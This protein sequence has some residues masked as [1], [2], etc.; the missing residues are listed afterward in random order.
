MT[1]INANTP[2]LK[3][4]KDMIDAYITLDISKVEPFVSKSFKYQTFPKVAD[5][6]EEPK[7]AHIQRF[8][9]MLAVMNKFEVRISNTGEAHQIRRLI[10]PTPRSFPTK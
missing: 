1:D 4:V 2:Q 3:A 5:L 9:R 6:P 10:R 7:A 8:G